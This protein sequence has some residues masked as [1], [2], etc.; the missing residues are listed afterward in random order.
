[1][2]FLSRPDARFDNSQFVSKTAGPHRAGQ[3]F[4]L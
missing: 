2:P 3:P 1:M 4:F